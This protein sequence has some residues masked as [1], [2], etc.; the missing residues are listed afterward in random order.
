MI[1]TITSVQHPIV[2]HLV[3]LRINRNY[4]YDHRTLAIEGMTLI[5]ELKSAKQFKLIATVNELLIPLGVEAEETIIVSESVMK[6]ISGVESPEGIVAEIAMPEAGSLL[7]KRHIL[8]L[9]GI[10]DPG[11]VGTL[12]RSALAFGWDGIFFLEG[13]CDPFNDKALRAARG[14]TF[15][16]PL[17]FGKWD[18]LK[19]LIEKNGLVPIVADISGEDFLEHPA[20]E[21]ILLVVGNE[22][23]G[24]SAI[25]RQVCRP[26]T[27]RMNKEVD[28][29]NVG[30]A[31][32]MMMY[33]LGRVIN[34]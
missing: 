23:T 20:L 29:L 18:Q 3:K 27:I 14:A 8:A 17:A 4:R 5:T 30:V 31:G 10:N 6:K 33:W 26:L 19:T 25:T 16:L 7:N 2:K 9:D 12:L 34:C 11:N 21:K 13:C 15:Q 28:S 32:S 22:S 24:P 1:R